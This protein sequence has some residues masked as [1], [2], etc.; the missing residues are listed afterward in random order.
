ML[1]PDPF[2]RSNRSAAYASLKKYEEAL[3]DAEKCTSIKPDWAK[4]SNKGGY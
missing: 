3:A 2:P 1:P 4:V